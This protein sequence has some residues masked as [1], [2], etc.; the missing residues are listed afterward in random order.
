M[1]RI[2]SRGVK[3]WPPSLF[4]S[5][6]L[7]SSPSYTWE[8][9]N[10]WVGSTASALI[11]CTLSRMSRR[12]RSVSMRVRSTPDMI[13]LTTRWR[14]VGSGRSSSARRCGTKSSLTNAIRP[15]RAAAASCLRFAPA[16]SAQSDQRYGASSV[17]VKS[18][19]TALACSASIASRSSRMRRNRIQVS[20]GT[21]WSAPAQLERRMMSQMDFTTALTDCGVAS[22]RPTPFALRGITPPEPVARALRGCP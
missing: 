14:G 4:F 7:R 13:S 8:R 11:S 5:P 1:A 17:G 10:T 19:P 22:L 12:L 20:S 6:I 2:T 21:Y 15:P 9:V 16:G 3:N 18:C